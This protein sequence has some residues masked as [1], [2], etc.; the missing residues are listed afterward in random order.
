[1]KHKLFLLALLLA[2]PS[3]IFGQTVSPDAEQPSAAEQPDA[4]PVDRDSLYSFLVEEGYAPTIDDDGDIEFKFYGVVCYLYNDGNYISL[5]AYYTYENSDIDNYRQAAM[6]VMDDIVMVQISVRDKADGCVGAEFAVGQ[7]VSS[8]E[9]FA[10]FYDSLMYILMR[11]IYG[12]DQE[13]LSL[14]ET[15]E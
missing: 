11:S 9:N 6:S 13:Y 5:R 8:I 15:A 10:Q 14:Q 1:M 2:L 7:F 3:C 12:F 4:T